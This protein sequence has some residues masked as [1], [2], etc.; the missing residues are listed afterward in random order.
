MAACVPHGVATN[1]RYRGADV[2]NMPEAS[3]Y[4]CDAYTEQLSNQLRVDA[5]ST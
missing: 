1:S 3:S 4:S 2:S 5:R